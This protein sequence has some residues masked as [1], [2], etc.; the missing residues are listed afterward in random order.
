MEIVG[1][2]ALGTVWLCLK[3][4][5]KLR[6]ALARHGERRTVTVKRPKNEAEERAETE[7]EALARLKEYEKRAEAAGAKY[8]RNRRIRNIAVSV[9]LLAA[10]LVGVAFVTTKCSK[11]NS[12][13]G[14]YGN[15]GYT[16]SIRYDANGGVFTTNTSIL[17]DTYSLDTLP[18]SED[19]TKIISLVDPNSEIRGNQ[20]YLAAKVGYHLAG[21]YAERNEVKDDN[22]NVIGY[23][24]GSKW[25]FLSSKYAISADASYD[26][27]RPVLT[28]YAAWVPDFVCEFYS[29][30]E[31]G[32]TLLTE[33]KFNPTLGNGIALP[34]YDA[35]S[36]TVKID[37]KTYEVYYTP[38]CSPDKRIEGGT[39][40]HSGNFNPY[41]A[42]LTDPVMKIYC[43]LVGDAS[44]D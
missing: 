1:V 16:V 4:R 32:I 15:K 42:T 29:V 39:V 2:A 41:D 33:K 12:P 14:D 37:G 17:V 5:R 25:D 28:L 10:M 36:G 3:H 26:P 30:D 19:G 24:Y 23:T 34:S 44:D 8:E 31:D 7:E 20:A 21:W 6:E 27:E 43:K 13:Y 22:G 11:D 18:T 35:E 9:I 40:T 38:D